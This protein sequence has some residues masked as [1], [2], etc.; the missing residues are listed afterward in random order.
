[1]PAHLFLSIGFT[2]LWQV[3]FAGRID[4]KEQRSVLSRCQAGAR[5]SLIL[6]NSKIT[7]LIE[8]NLLYLEQE[9]LQVPQAIAKIIPYGP[10]ATMSEHIPIIIKSCQFPRGVGTCYLK[11]THFYT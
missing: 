4:S 7:L 8:E 9:Q 2:Y 5:A 10:I 11:N 6:Y 1:M 3:V